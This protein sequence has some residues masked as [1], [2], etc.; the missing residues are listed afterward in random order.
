MRAAETHMKKHPSYGAAV[1][2]Q[3]VVK[4]RERLIAEM[5]RGWRLVVNPLADML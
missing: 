2:L 4:E 1:T 5:R 3:R